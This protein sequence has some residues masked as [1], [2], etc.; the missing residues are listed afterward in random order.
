MKRPSALTKQTSTPRSLFSMAALSRLSSVSRTAVN[1]AP[2]VAAK[3]SGT[4]F[5]PYL[6][7]A[8]TAPADPHAHGHGAPTARSDA[9]PAWASSSRSKST[10]T[11]LSKTFVNGKLRLLALKPN[12]CVA[13]TGSHDANESPT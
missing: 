9:V 2:T 10:G 8:A 3:A 6:N 7:L 1:V 11:L 12:F 5:A 13:N 4:P